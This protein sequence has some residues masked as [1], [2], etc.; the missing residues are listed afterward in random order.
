[1]RPFLPVPQIGWMKLGMDLFLAAREDLHPWEGWQIYCHNLRTILK[2]QSCFLR[3]C[4]WQT[5]QRQFVITGILKVVLDFIAH[6]VLLILI[7]Q[8]SLWKALECFCPSQFLYLS[9]AITKWLLIKPQGQFIDNSKWK[10]WP[11]VAVIT[12]PQKPQ[13]NAVI[14]KLRIFHL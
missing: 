5:V 6:V 7:L 8:I 9:K 2:V 1:M 12:C 11:H 4:L 3:W 13:P 10:P 14:L